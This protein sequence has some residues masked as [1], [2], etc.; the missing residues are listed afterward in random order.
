MLDNLP[1]NRSDY[2]NVMVKLSKYI[3]ELTKYKDTFYYGSVLNGSIQNLFIL[4]SR[5]LYHSSEETKCI[6]GA[7]RIMNLVRDF[8]TEAQVLFSY[9]PD[10]AMWDHRKY[11][12]NGLVGKD[13]SYGKAPPFPE[14]FE[15]IRTEFDDPLKTFVKK[16]D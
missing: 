6:D 13:T 1:D 16:Y 11:F 15:I 7:N 3:F 9:L 4:V 5:A 14:K 10:Y 8:L 12:E 2:V